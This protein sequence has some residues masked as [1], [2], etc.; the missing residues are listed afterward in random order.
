M[1]EAVD[2]LLAGAADLPSP[3][4]RARLRKAAGL[5]QEQVG[6]ALGVTWLAVLRW[7]KGQ[8]EPRAARRKAYVKLLNGWSERYPDALVGP[9]R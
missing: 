8:S 3:A 1:M 5:T 6:E 7:E 4:T 9:E 2:Q